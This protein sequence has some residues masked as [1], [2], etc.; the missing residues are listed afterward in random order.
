MSSPATS[1]LDIPREPVA[2]ARWVLDRYLIEEP[3]HIT[4]E[5]IAMDLGLSIEDGELSGAGARLTRVADR[6]IIRITDTVTH[7][8][9]RRFS[10][11]HELGHFLLAH[12]ECGWVRCL[13]EEM[14]AFGGKPSAETEANAFATELLLPETMIRSRVERPEM[15]L[16]A[17]IRLA[18]DFQT[19]V[20]SVALR[21]VELTGE[22]RALVLSDSSRV[23]WWRRS[24]T[25]GCWL[26][27]RGQ[28]IHADSLAVRYFLRKEVPARPVDVP[29]EA[30]VEDRDAKGH[31]I[32]E[33]AMV[34]P[35]M[36]A[37]LSLLTIVPPAEQR[38]TD[39]ARRA[40][41][42][43]HSSEPSRDSNRA[44]PQRTGPESSDR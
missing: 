31:T 25:F 4:I 43:S 28:E 6:G 29:A 32:V 5:A 33:D 3:E 23:S 37:V 11:A 22:R 39:S 21:F 41:T 2:A 42:K 40:P 12:Q 16:R 27:G 8:G 34:I 18:K 1:A 36:K 14:H 7:A 15:N 30:W 17:L 26:R 19:S 35:S 24:K 38:T 10:I 20:T 9:R 13:E 44:R